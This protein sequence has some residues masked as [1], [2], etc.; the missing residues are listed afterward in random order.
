MRQINK[1]KLTETQKKLTK[2]LNT[3]AKFKKYFCEGRVES[4]PPKL[5]K[6]AKQ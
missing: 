1:P 5:P 3:P 6:E 2:K 4:T